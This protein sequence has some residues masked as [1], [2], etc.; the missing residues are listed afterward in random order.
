M[1]PTSR[2][3]L[4]L[5]GFC[6]LCLGVAGAQT[7][8]KVTGPCA[9]PRQA[10]H[11]FLDNLQPDNWAPVKAARC[12][13][14]PAEV[15]PAELQTRVERFKA[16][17]DHRGLWVKVE[18][19]PDAP[20]FKDSE[21]RQK[22]QLVH[23]LTAAYLVRVGDQWL[24]PDTV[25]RR[26]PELYSATFSGWFEALIQALPASLRAKALGY[27][28]WQPIFLVAL[29]LLC[30]VVSRLVRWVVRRRVTRLLSRFEETNEV[31]AQ[32]ARPIGVLA[33]CGLFVL[34]LPELRLPIG[35]ASLLGIGARVVAAIAA[36]V[37]VYRLV[38]LVVMRLAA[39]AGDTDSRTDDQLVVLLRKI[40]RV[41]VVAVGVV[42]ILQNLHIDVTSLLAGLGIGGLALA[43]AAK[44]TAANLFGSITLLIDQPF[45]VGDAISAAGVDGVVLDV[46]LRST[47]V[48]TYEDTEVSIPNSKLANSNIEN[49]SRR[50]YR[51]YTTT[52]GLTYDAQPDQIRAFVEGIRGIIAAQ[53]KTR[54]DAYEVHFSGY[55]A[56]SLDVML[57]AHFLVASSSEMHLAKQQLLLEIMRLAAELGV[58]FAFPTQTIHM[59]TPA[60]APPDTPALE[61]TVAAYAPGGARSQPEPKPLTQGYLPG[62]V[63]G[64]ENVEGGE[65]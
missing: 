44:D 48:K 23:G 29:L 46:G 43:L 51:R 7:A 61:A 4:F 8:P 17:L 56:A 16:V 26:V 24:F 39:R 33:G 55:G 54:K 41:I 22:V 19:L 64:V 62:T 11:T 30:F 9:T 60:A 36:V 63:E 47:R 18:A 14:R 52:L 21:G 37:L 6:Q 27:A 59:A 65:A 12:F 58:E 10:A 35:P 53:P 13:Q 32:A 45:L 42:F 31:I 3:C 15:E 49:F 25:V 38:D 5:L 2:I 34:A 1:R 50:T 40:L 20:D 57:Q 28:L